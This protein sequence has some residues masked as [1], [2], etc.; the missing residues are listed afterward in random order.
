M[1]KL[2]SNFFGRNKPQEVQAPYKIE[3]PTTPVV[4]TPQVNPVGGVVNGRAKSAPK[5]VADT[6]SGVSTGNVKKAA[7][8]KK[9][10]PGANKKG[11]SK[12]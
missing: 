9:T 7:P 8:K 2:F 5:K 11:T 12:K 10:S 1:L 6:A 3:T 4:E